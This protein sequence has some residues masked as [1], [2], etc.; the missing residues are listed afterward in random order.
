MRSINVLNKRMPL[1]MLLLV[2]AAV[3]VPAEATKPPKLPKPPAGQGM[4][5]VVLWEPG[6]PVPDAP[7][8]RIERVPEP[9]IEKVGGRLLEKKNN[10]RVVFLPPQAAKQLQKHQAVA[11]VQRIWMGEA[12]D[13][14]DEASQVSTI[15]RVRNDSDPDLSWG[16]KT[17]TYDRSG[18]IKQFGGDSYAY[19][20][21]GRLISSTVSGKTE[22]YAYDT[23]GNLTAKTTNGNT[24]TIPVDPG[25]NHIL[26][27]EYD[28]NGNQTTSGHRVYT[29]DALNMITSTKVAGTR[30]IL[31][32]ANDERIGTLIDSTLSRWTLRDFEGQVVRE[33]KGE[34]YGMGML[35]TWELDHFR[36][37][38]ILLGGESQSWAYNGQSSG[39]HKGGGLRHHH[40]DHLGSVRMVTNAAGRSLSQND[41]YPFGTTITKMFQEPINWGD[42]HVDMMRFAGHWR[43]NLGYVGAESND[44]LDYMHARYYDPVVGRFLSVDPNRRKALDLPMGWNGYTYVLN[45]PTVRVDPSGAVDCEPE[46]D[47]CLEQ[48]VLGPDDPQARMQETI[49]VTAPDPGPLKGLMY[50]VALNLTYGRMGRGIS[51]AEMA[52]LNGQNHLASALMRGYQP[53]PP[54]LTGVVFFGAT[55]SGLTRQ[56]ELQ[57]ASSIFTSGGEL[58]AEAIAESTLLKAPGTLGNPAIPQG[59]GKYSTST[60]RSPSGP[61]RVH[62]YMNPRTGQTYYGLDYK[63][64]A[65]RF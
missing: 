40:L 51:Q 49:T 46:E 20:S 10:T 6:T 35:W 16:P 2:L 37:D 62:Y 13:D 44:Y 8:E 42:P 11:Y 50:R 9:D 31:Y 39:T 47:G 4:Y 32:D 17:I 7:A 15:L 33:Y 24:V 48:Q 25:S 36:G 22:T 53:P 43:D 52:A 5:M 61:F 30:R 63:A 27:A 65:V 21:V 55:S 3:T 41:F 12:L 60:Y 45:R 34:S 57:E 54:V 64:V 59:F 18:N 26:G 19:D 29:Y 14:L 38:G 56:L 28:A 58:T 1:L 23:F